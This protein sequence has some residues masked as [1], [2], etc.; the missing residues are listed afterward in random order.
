MKTM[1]NEEQIRCPKC[2][3]TQIHA[4]KRGFKTG[5]AVAGG[6][7][8]GNIIVAMTA[9]GI[10]KNNIELTCLKCGN[11]F[12]PGEGISFKHVEP[13]EVRIS[14]GSA[15]YIDQEQHL[16]IYKCSNC[17]KISSISSDKMICP[18][19]GNMITEQDKYSYKKEESISIIPIVITAIIVC[20][21]ALI[22]GLIVRSC[23]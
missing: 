10:G 20:T 15:R 22:L 11:K 19:C 18:K 23:N 14:K 21:I 3:S 6:I 8:T 1:N 16:S 17:G 7:V 12:K 5:R 13:T 2:G 4:E 9:G